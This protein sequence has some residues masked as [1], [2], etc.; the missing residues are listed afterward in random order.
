MSVATRRIQ[1]LLGLRGMTRQDL[2]RELG[3]DKGALTRY[4]NG[5]LNLAQAKG[6]INIARIATV[7]DVPESSLMTGVPCPC[8][9]RSKQ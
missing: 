9:S 6:A 4:L 7:L 5:D 3:A 8:C 1:A 2:A